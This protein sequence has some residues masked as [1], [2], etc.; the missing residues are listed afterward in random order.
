MKNVRNV[1]VMLAIFAGSLGVWE[2]V[3][4]A[5]AIPIFILPPPS[6]VV[7]ALYRGIASGVYLEIGRAHV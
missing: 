1:A 7:M 4:R 5:F 3:V 2:A 6:Q